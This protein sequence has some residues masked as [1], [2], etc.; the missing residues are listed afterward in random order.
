MVFQK[1]NPNMTSAEL[2]TA[3][4]NAAISGKLTTIN[5]GDD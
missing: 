3:L 2:A 1:A 5:T 4:Y